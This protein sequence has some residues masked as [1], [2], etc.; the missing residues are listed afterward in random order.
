MGTRLTF[1][2]RA[3]RLRA[4]LRAATGADVGAAAAR[5]AIRREIAFYRAHLHTAVDG[6]SLDALR[7]R[8]AAAMRTALPPGASDEALTVALLAGIRFAP[9]PEVPGALATLRAAGWALVVVS[10]WDVSLDEVL[11]ETGLRERVDGVVASVAVGAPK[12]ARAAF[13]RGLE[14]AGAAPGA[15]WH[16][17][18]DLEADVGG[19]RAAG[20]RPVLVDRDGD[21]RVPRGGVPVVRALDELPGL[22]GRPSP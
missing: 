8:C 12:P 2:P 18:D 14:L 6:P 1:E 17:G 7:A 11:V 22:V 16:V 19:A 4:A 21:R 10:N 9:Y 20:L 5:E 3:P 15:A 13:D